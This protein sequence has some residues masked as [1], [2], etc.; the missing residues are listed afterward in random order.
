VPL[1]LPLDIGVYGFADAGRVYLD[2][3]SPGGWHTGTGIGFWVGILN[4]S[5]ALTVELGKHRGRSLTR[6]KT[7]LNF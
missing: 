1:V 5:T 7:G 3:A 4:P 6:I 2:G